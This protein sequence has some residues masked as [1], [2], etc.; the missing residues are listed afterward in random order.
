[1]ATIVPTAAW[2]VFA[3]AAGAR[4]VAPYGGMLQRRG[5]AAKSDEVL[6]M[7]RIIDAQQADAELCVGIYDVTEF[8]FYAREGV[9]SCFVWG[10]DVDS[11]LTQPLV[12]E[13]AQGFRNDWQAM[14]KY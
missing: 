6:A 10:K 2:L 8:P 11:F 13:A 9:R 4:A 14:E 7:Q 5:L 12:D 3:L 1:M